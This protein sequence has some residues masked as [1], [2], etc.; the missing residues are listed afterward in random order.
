MHFLAEA[1]STLSGMEIAACGVI[2]FGASV[3]LIHTLFRTPATSPRP[4]RRV[5]S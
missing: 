4:N 2:L 3:I 5:S 1:I